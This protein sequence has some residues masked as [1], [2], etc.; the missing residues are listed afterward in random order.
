M[1]QL[2]RI[3]TSQD[4]CCNR[5]NYCI[6]GYS[7]TVTRVDGRA[8]DH[9]CICTFQIGTQ[10]ESYDNVFTDMHTQTYVK[11]ILGKK[12]NGDSIYIEC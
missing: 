10:W 3:T 8:L 7:Y 1:K 2:K 4:K 6:C 11:L 12:I 5:T 9:V